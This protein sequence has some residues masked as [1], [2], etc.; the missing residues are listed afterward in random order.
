MKEVD[1]RGI[2]CPMP[3][4]MAKR[5]VKDGEETF[6]VLVNEEIAV[7]NLKKMAQQ[8]NYDVTVEKKDGEEFELIFQKSSKTQDLEAD[9]FRESKSYVVVFDSDKLG[10][11]DEEFSKKLIESF[12]L[13][14]IKRGKKSFDETLAY[15]KNGIYITNLEGVGTGLSMQTGNYSLQADGFL[16]KDGKLDRAVSLIT[17]AGN[18]FDDFK[19]IAVVSSDSEITLQGISTPPLAIRKLSISGK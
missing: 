8:V 11:G 5:L 13:A 2:E 1:A 10:E 9:T 7:E 14:L 4:I 18:V 16:I 19:R 12:L 6:K 17:V 3:V 15:I